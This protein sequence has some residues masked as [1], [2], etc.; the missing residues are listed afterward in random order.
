MRK[1]KNTEQERTIECKFI[2]LFGPIDSHLS[3]DVVLSIMKE[4]KKAIIII[5]NSEGGE[6]ASGG[7]IIDAM[8]WT[9]VPVYTLVIGAS[10]SMA[11]NISIMGDKR[12]CTPL[13]TFMMH[14]TQYDFSPY[15]HPTDINDLVN[16]QKNVDNDLNKMILEKTKITKQELIAS[17]DSR[18]DIYYDSKTAIKKKV[19]DHII[20][21]EDDLIK[22]LI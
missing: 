20:D 3:K 10:Y 7:A 8:R 2:P 12:F 18:R 9:D 15:S 11:F 6:V 13:S 14:D 22:Y 5:I 17:L 16:F 19:V 4:R 1:I 21:N